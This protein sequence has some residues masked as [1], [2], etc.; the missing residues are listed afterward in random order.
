M[1]TKKSAALLVR[2]RDSHCPHCG[3]SENLVVHHRRN[4]QMGGSKILDRPDN[5]LL[6]C[7]AWNVEI[8]SNANAAN[9][10]REWGHKLGSWNGFDTPVFDNTESQ[11]WLL[12]QFGAKHKTTPPLYLI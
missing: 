11:W 4:R 1:A 2:Q 3:Q 12:D 10:A 5:L 9:Q 7:A 6:I 8:E